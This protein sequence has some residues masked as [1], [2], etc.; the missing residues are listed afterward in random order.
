M[1][2]YITRIGIIVCLLIMTAVPAFGAIAL[3]GLIDTG[4][5]FYSID[6]GVSW[7]VQA[8]LP[9]PD[10]VGLV[11]GYSAKQLYL[12]TRSGTVYR[13][14]NNGADWTAVGGV[15]A[16]DVVA[17]TV[18]ADGELVVLTSTGTVWA[19]D[20]GGASFVVS[21]V[22]D[23]P[24][25]V[26][27]VRTHTGILY[28]LTETG[29]VSESLDEGSSWETKGFIT[30]PDAVEIVSVGSNLYVLAGT[31]EIWQSTD[32]GT[33]WLAIA[34]V[35]QVRMSGMVLGRDGALY[36][37]T[38]EGEVASST[39]GVDWTWVGAIGQLNVVSLASDLPLASVP[40][41]DGVSARLRL[42]VPRPNPW[43]GGNQEFTLPFNLS[44]PGNIRVDLIDAQGKLVAHRVSERFS[45]PGLHS[46]GWNPGQFA[47][48]VYYIRAASQGEVRSQK[49]VVAR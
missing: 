6:S 45:N 34:T 15:D 46:I 38:R 17:I 12:V 13:S 28:A 31:G 5:V 7:Q 2:S 4:E 3:F 24:D 49:I 20:D 43:H 42:G 11:A 35:S 40:R 36:V 41:D 33:T 21:S 47:S 26:S 18:M 27:L 19:S 25:C 37:A 16:S 14:D 32:A 8:V 22:L 48:G 23:A 29:E 39:D 30:I 10:A 44:Q 1:N 9:T